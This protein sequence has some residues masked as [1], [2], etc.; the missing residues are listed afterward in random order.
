LQNMST[1]WN[2]EYVFQDGFHAKSYG[3]SNSGNIVIV[4]ADKAQ[5]LQDYLVLGSAS[6]FEKKE[7][8][9]YIELHKPTIFNIGQKEYLIAFN[10]D[11]KGIMKDPYENILL[12]D[13]ESG[14]IIANDKAVGL[15]SHKDIV[16]VSIRNLFVENNEIVIFS[17]GKLKAGTKE[18]K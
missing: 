9:T 8:S 1:V 12:Y 2:K 10:K 14:N 5:K 4:A 17:E 3:V 11:V 15:Y 16:D 13:L 6:G 7:F 18:Q